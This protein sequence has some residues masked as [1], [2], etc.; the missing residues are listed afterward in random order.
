MKRISMIILVFIGLMMSSFQPVVKKESVTSII[1]E[2]EDQL[3]KDI[4]VDD[5][6]GSISAA[7]VFENE[8]IWSKA[9]GISNLNTNTISDKS[10]IY[11]TGSIS[12]S[13]TAFLMMLL[14]QEGIINLDDPIENYFEEI[15]N[16][17]GYSEATKITFRQLASH[18]SGLVREPTLKNAA[19]GIIEEWDDKVVQSIPY[20]FFE[21]KPGERYSYS[22]IGYGIL[23]VALSRAAD[24]PFIK[25][26]ENK[27]F[28]PLQMTNSFF[29]VPDRKTEHLAIGMSG[30]PLEGI[31]F[32]KPKKEHAGRGY[33]VPNGGI[34]STPNDLG[35]FMICTMGYSALLD[36]N[37]LKEMRVNHNPDEEL[38]K[39][40]LGFFLYQDSILS[41]VGHGGYVS[42]YTAHFEFD[43]ESKYGVILMRNYNRGS[44][45]L[46]TRSKAVLRK[47]KTL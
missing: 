20:T 17:N 38:R 25:L 47:L 28:K 39:Y 37:R 42:G 15:K 4:T 18:T 13:F 1:N 5:I 24:T 26:V 30:G 46:S 35:K 36:Q 3:T 41:T 29:I 43:N 8:I 2:F 44:T 34:Y 40:G 23:G 21:S 45:N 7:I 22:N 33:K 32:E 12:K 16:S 6:H 31:D 11:R 10:T 14:V 27:I 19:S 9:F